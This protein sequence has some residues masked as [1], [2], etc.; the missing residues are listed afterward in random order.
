MPSETIAINPCDCGCGEDAGFWG[1]TDKS[2]GRIEGEPKRF[3]HGHNRRRAASE[4][5]WEKVD[6]RGECWIWT[7]GTSAAGYGLFGSGEQGKMV[8]AHR[9]AYQFEAGPIPDGLELDHLCRNPR[10]V[11]PDHLEPVT[12]QENCKRGKRGM[13]RD[14]KPR[15]A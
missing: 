3:A 11:N 13:L 6:K 10:C 5:F 8:Y 7:A 4:R 1:Y 14:S 15:L 2:Q 9:T 12:H